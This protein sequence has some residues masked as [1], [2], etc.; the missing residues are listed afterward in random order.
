MFTEG[1]IVEYHGRRVTVLDV[2]DAPTPSGGTVKLVRVQDPKRGQRIL[3]ASQ[4][5]L[6]PAEPRGWRDDEGERFKA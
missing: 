3:F 4:L 1:Q 5:E 6:P 2:R